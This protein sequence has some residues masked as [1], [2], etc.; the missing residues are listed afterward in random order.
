MFNRSK[1]LILAAASISLTGCFEVED[2]NNEDLVKALEEQNAILQEQQHLAAGSVTL[3]GNIVNANDDIS[4]ENATVKVKVGATWHEPIE[5][6]GEFE[7]QDLPANTDVILLVQSTDNNFLDRVF[8]GRTSNTSGNQ[9]A[10]QSIGDLPVS[11]G[12]EKTYSILDAETNTAFEGLKFSYNPTFSFGGSYIDTSSSILSS[13]EITS[14]FDDITGLYSI[15]VPED[16]N[17][18]ITAKADI[19]GD[20]IN[21]FVTENNNFF[22][23]DAIQISG[24]DAHELE[25]LY[26]NK[27]AEYQDIEVRVSVIDALGNSFENLDFFIDDQFTGRIDANIDNDTK[28]YIFNYQASG[29]LT[30][31][32][33]SFNSEDNVSYD[34]GTIRISR[35]NEDDL[36]VYTSGFENYLNDEISIVDGIVA[37]TVMPDLAYTPNSYISTESSA[38]D[39]DDNHSLKE[40]YQAPITLLN[41]SVILTKN[42]VLTVVK[43]NDVAN[44]TVALGTTEIEL[45][46]QEI[47][48]DTNLTHNNTF[49]TAKAQQTL[50]AGEYRYTVNNLVNANDDVEFN[51][52]AYQNFTVEQSTNGLVF[53]IN[54][55]KIDNHNG[56]TNGVVTVLTNTANIANTATN[57]YNKNYLYLPESIKTLDLLEFTYISRVYNG[58]TY[59]ENEQINI[60]LD[61]YKNYYGY[62]AIKLAANETIRSINVNNY[63]TTTSL[64]DGLWYRSNAYLNYSYD[65]TSGQENTVTFNYIYRVAG[66]ENT[67]EGTITL[68]VM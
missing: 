60:I 58:T 65:N 38:I 46:S 28:E 37:I 56:T 51:K 16:F 32:L 59:E 33:A 61:N 47:A 52:N 26:V 40:F 54:D 30:L 23:N 7:I 29:Q 6:A 67:V 15:N 39:E 19:D 68:P 13:Y 35:N 41:D 1:I 9:I 64:S 4:T 25:T 2:S 22:Y 18:T 24:N 42:D 55:I 63:V 20:D 31:N 11:Q 53:D 44:D 10:I 21:D 12:T 45:I 50:E 8:Y 14:T 43:G 5:T 27:T 49:L 48:I 17:V 36:S 62:Y 66:E 57:N 34:S 3:Y